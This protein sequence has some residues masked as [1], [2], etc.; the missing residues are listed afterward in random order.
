[1]AEETPGTIGAA[2][3]RAF[4]PGGPRP[5]RAPLP[6]HVIQAV[7]STPPRGK[8]SRQYK[9]GSEGVDERVGDFFGEVANVLMWRRKMLRRVRAKTRFS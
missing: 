8:G 9:R 1:V 7:S 6:S 5:A 3:R 2:S 4:K